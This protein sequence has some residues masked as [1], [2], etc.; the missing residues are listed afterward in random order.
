MTVFFFSNF[1]EYNE[2][3]QVYFKGPNILY[4][5]SGQTLLD[6]DSSFCIIQ[7][8][9]E[10]KNAANQVLD[11]LLSTPA[12]KMQ[13]KADSKAPKKRENKNGNFFFI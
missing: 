9:E 2:N 1:K 6:S 4:Q 3:L 12:D 13:T 5:P 8:N 7:E 10:T 11:V